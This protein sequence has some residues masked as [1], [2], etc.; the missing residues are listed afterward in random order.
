M[1]KV[2]SPVYSQTHPRQVSFLIFVRQNLVKS[3]AVTGVEPLC[4]MKVLVR[5]FGDMPRLGITQT[6]VKEQWNFKRLIVTVFSL[7]TQTTA[8]ANYSGSII[9]W[10]SWARINPRFLRQFAMPLPCTLIVFKLTLVFEL[11]SSR[12]WFLI[13]SWK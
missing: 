12:F 2:Q 1:K 7:P 4:V 6:R 3:H 8:F 10:Y 5:K 11:K 13:I 9:F